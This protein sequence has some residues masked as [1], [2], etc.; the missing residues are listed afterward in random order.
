MYLKKY[1]FIYKKKKNNMENNIYYIFYV[2][3]K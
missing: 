3:F 2:L 1:I